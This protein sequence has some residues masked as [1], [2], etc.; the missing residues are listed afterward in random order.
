M[1]KYEQQEDLVVIAA[2]SNG[3]EA[4]LA[5]SKLGTEGI[6]AYVADEYMIGINPAYDIAL[7]GVKLKTK[8]SE[9]LKALK[10]LERE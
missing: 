9:A 10:I 4:H 7:G 2:F 1:K 3:A 6:E 8:R 5:C